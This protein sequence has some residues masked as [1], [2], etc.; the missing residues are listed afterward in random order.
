[1]TTTIS[2]IIYVNA[3]FRQH[4]YYLSLP[5]TITAI[6]YVILSETTYLL[7]LAFSKISICLFL[8][9]IIKN[10]SRD[11]MNQ[12]FLHFTMG[13]LFITTVTYVSQQVANVDLHPSFG[14]QRFPR[15]A[16][17]LVFRRSSATSMVV[18]FPIP[19]FG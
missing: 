12:V 13:L 14:T 10:S 6:K 11:N 5:S 2:N 19:V 16:K 15:H 7:S 1:M 17:T 8:L 9:G 4:A 3:G 18:N